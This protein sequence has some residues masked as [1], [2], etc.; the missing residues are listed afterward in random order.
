MVHKEHKVYAGIAMRPFDLWSRKV[1]C[2]GED[3]AEGVYQA[4]K[5]LSQGV[6][7]ACDYFACMED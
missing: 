6:F 3:T 2:D 7:T 5:G 1:M 4:M